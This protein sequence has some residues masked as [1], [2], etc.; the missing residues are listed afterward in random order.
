MKKRPSVL[1]IDE[2]FIKTVKQTIKSFGVQ[3]IPFTS[4]LKVLGY[5][6]LTGNS[7]T[8][9][10]AVI[11]VCGVEM[12]FKIEKFGRS[13]VLIPSCEET[14]AEKE[15]YSLLDSCRYS[16]KFEKR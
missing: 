1:S 5:T 12:G 15:L 8:L 9:L 7:H 13:L 4:I 11:A 2:E 16:E 6:R 14:Q 3:V 10:T